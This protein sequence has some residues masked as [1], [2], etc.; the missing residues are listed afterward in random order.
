MDLLSKLEEVMEKCNKC[1]EFTDCGY[2]DHIETY[3]TP[4]SR[5]V[6]IVDDDF[7]IDQSFW[8]TAYNY[9]LRIEEFAI[10]RSQNCSNL[11]ENGYRC[12]DWVKKF[13]K[14]VDPELIIT[15]GGRSVRKYA[16]VNVDRVG[17]SYNTVTRF[18]SVDDNYK[19]TVIAVKNTI[20]GFKA[21]FESMDSIL[22]RG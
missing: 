15:M 19:Y 1:Y 22:R 12:H 18:D 8:D 5:F 10:I 7:V 4:L 14:I 16:R 3:W 11:S 21:L 6:M 2:L 20:S 9:T 13:V 17:R